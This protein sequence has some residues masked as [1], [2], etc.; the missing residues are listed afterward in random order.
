MRTLLQAERV[1]YAAIF[2]VVGVFMASDALGASKIYKRVD[3]NGNVVFTDVPPAAN[4]QAETV[5]INSPNTYQ[6][7]DI[8]T[9]EGDRQP[10]IVAADDETSD[11][12]PAAPYHSLTV[13]SPEDDANIRENAGNVNIVTAVQ[14]ALQPGHRL[15]L[16]LDD[17]PVGP[18]QTRPVFALTNVDRGTHRVTPQVVDDAG[19]VLFSGTPSI[20]HLQRFSVLNAPGRPG[21]AGNN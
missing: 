11:A 9:V 3:A 14:P 17:A 5:E 10:W 8:L 12:P 13:R 2:L 21:P 6:R 19:T 20:F 7:D 4:E 1:V 16:L 18:S 15:R